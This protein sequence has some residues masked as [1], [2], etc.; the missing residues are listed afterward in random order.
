[1][2]QIPLS[3]LP[4]TGK[5]LPATMGRVLYWYDGP[6][7]FDVTQSHVEGRVMAMA[8]PD[9]PGWVDT[10][11]AITLTSEIETLANARKA[12]MRMIMTRPEACLWRIDYVGPD[13]ELTMSPIQGPV[14][15]AF[16]P[17]WGVYLED[18]EVEE[19][20]E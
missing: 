9:A 4:A 18:Y 10:F 17:D 12:D 7:A 14:P 11:V 6:V 1:M 20:K 5:A 2:A 8:V 15:D 13:R 3:D 16:L 19:E